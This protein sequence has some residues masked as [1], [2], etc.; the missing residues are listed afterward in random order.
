MSA[1]AD[2]CI[3]IHGTYIDTRICLIGIEAGCANWSKE[4]KERKSV[5]NLRLN[6]KDALGVWLKQWGL[7]RAISIPSES[8]VTAILNEQRASFM[9]CNAGDAW[10]VDEIANAMKDIAELNKRHLSLAAKFAFS[11]SPGVFFPY[12]QYSRRALLVLLPGHRGCKSYAE[13]MSKV[14]PLLADY[15]KQCHKNRRLGKTLAN[16]MN[17]FGLGVDQRDI[18]LRRGL[19]KTLMLIGGFGRLRMDEEVASVRKVTRGGRR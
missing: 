12:D 15:I 17:E 2:Y 16:A 7:R 10:K 8:I 11:M 18:C 6:K 9:R 19:D 13:Y 1:G 5:E 3:E 4:S 14:E